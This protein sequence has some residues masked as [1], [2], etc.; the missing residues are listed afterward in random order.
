MLRAIRGL[1]R[2]TGWTERTRAE[3]PHVTGA[4]RVF[5]DAKAHDSLYSYVELFRCFRDAVPRQPTDPFSARVRA[6]QQGAIHRS[7]TSDNHRSPRPTRDARCATRRVFVAEVGRKSESRRAS[8][9]EYSSSWQKRSAMNRPPLF[10]VRRILDYHSRGV[11][12]SLF[13]DRTASAAA[14][15][16]QS[17][18]APTTESSRVAW[19]WRRLRCG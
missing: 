10:R 8:S 14:D 5:E 18:N 15:A 11:P 13:R 6:T 4:N 1:T 2:L 3:P 17:V 19:R 12:H 7:R 9:E 16:L